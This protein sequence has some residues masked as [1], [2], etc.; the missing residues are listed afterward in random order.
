MDELRTVR[1]V[2]QQVGLEKPT[3]HLVIYGD[4]EKPRHSEFLNVDRLLEALRTAVPSLDLSG[5]SLNPVRDGLG[6]IV[7]AGELLLSATQIAALGLS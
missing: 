2:I 5:Y 7:F 4:Q 1:M 6:S 3:Y